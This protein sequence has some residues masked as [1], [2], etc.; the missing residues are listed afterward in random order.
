MTNLKDHLFSDRKNFELGSLDESNLP[1]APA[2]L[3]ENWLKEAIS[4]QNPEPYAF[5]LLTLGKDGFPSGRIVYLRALEEEGELVFFTNYGSLKGRE[6]ASDERV[7]AHFFWPN[8]ERQVRVWGLA[9][10]VSEEFSDAY[11]ASRPRESQ[12]GAWTSQQS[13][14]L[15]GRDE[16]EAAFQEFVARFEGKE[17]PRPDFWGGYEIIPVKYE[18]WQGRANRLHDRIVYNKSGKDWNIKRLYP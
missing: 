11:F 14:E 6:I 16:L 2:S 18:F 5:T 7:G 4:R 13:A 17:I 1:D 3:F 9:S 12:I 8:S 15:S 10:P